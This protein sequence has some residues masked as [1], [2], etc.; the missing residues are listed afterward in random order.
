[1]LGV[2]NDNLISHF[3]AAKTFIPVLAPGGTYLSIGGGT[4]DFIMPGMGQ[5]S[6]GQAALRMMIRAIAGDH[7][8]AAT[9]VHELIIASMVNGEK[10]RAV[11]APDWLTEIEVGEHVATIIADPASFPGPILTLKSR[12][13][14]GRP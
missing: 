10:R 1:M 14:V 2:L 11:A 4:A 5:L 7:R 9:H 12:D 8:G 3:A 6:I 13:Q